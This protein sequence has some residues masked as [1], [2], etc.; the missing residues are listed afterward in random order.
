ML[1]WAS[2]DLTADRLLFNVLWTVWIYVRTTLEEADLLA[3]FGD[4]YRDCRRKVPMLIP[5]RFS[6]H[7]SYGETHANLG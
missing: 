1:I 5:W 2:S 4:A 6:A 7:P 3:N